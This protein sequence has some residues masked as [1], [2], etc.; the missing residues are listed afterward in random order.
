M[1]EGEE[2]ERERERESQACNTHS[3]YRSL[4]SFT[5][6]RPVSSRFASKPTHLV[7][8]GTSEEK[9]ASSEGGEIEKETQRG[10][11]NRVGNFKVASSLHNELTMPLEIPIL[12]ELRNEFQHP[13]RW[14]KERER[15]RG[16]EG[17]RKRG[18]K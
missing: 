15:V 13:F 3:T 2:R 4:F 9:E 11:E 1:R 10:A 8:I 18:E 6:G 5:C 17:E 7:H 16:G 14:Y 12:S